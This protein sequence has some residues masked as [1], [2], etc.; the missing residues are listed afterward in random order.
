[1]KLSRNNWHGAFLPN[2]KSESRENENK[3]FH[4]SNTLISSF[5][6]IL[7]TKDQCNPPPLACVYDKRD[8]SES[9][10]SISKGQTFQRRRHGFL[11]RN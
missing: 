6:F 4:H 3:I 2:I 1:M 11:R 5:F 10:N 9:F 8:R 7:G